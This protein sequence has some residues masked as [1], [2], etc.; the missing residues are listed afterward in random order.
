MKCKRELSEP[1]GASAFKAD[2]PA[3]AAIGVKYVR[4]HGT[5]HSKVQNP[6][7]KSVRLTT[8]LHKMVLS[9][10]F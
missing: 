4:V 6:I 3:C 10:T 5:N 9:T 8:L 7:C 1:L 2:S